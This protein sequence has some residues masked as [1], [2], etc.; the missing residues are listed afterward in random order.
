[1]RF[2]ILSGRCEIYTSG[3]FL[4]KLKYRVSL[5]LLV[6]VLLSFVLPISVNAQGIAISG[7]FYR[8]HFRLN[9]GESL[10]TPEIYVV[11][12][13]HEKNDIRVTLTP[14]APPGVEIHLEES[15]FIIPAGGDNKVEVGVEVGREAV[16]GEYTLTITAEIQQD[17][18]GIVVVGAAQEQARLT[19]LGES[20]EVRINTVTCLGEPF[21]AEIKVCQSQDGER[22]PCAYSAGGQLKIKL[23]PGDYG[24]RATFQDT[25]VAKQAFSLQADETKQ[26]NVIVQTVFIYGFSIVPNYYEES[27]EISFTKV[28]YTINNIYQPIK[29]V[30]VIL[31]VA[32]DGRLL[33]EDEI[34]SLPTLDVGSTGGGYNYVPAQEW[35][36]GTYNFKMNLYSQNKLCAESPEEELK[37]TTLQAPTAGIDWILTGIIAGAILLLIVVIFLVAGRRRKRREE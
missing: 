4:R 13:N 35:Q 32:L 29:D 33:E 21:P 14:Q 31:I 22:S 30:S 20:G 3:H 9:P 6:I 10:N 11:V 15:D 25:E 19:I 1:M 16:P 23:A 34:I 26:I 7:S 8:H 28:P 24:I 37:I 17:G 5:L 18:E 12:F 27:G 2:S 36:N